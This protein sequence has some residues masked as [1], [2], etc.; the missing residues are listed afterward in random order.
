MPE[1]PDDVHERAVRSADARGEN[2][3]QEV[4]NNY[5]DLAKEDRG[6]T[7]QRTSPQPASKADNADFI[8]NRKPITYRVL[9]ALEGI[10]GVRVYYPRTARQYSE[11]VSRL[12]GQGLTSQSSWGVFSPAN[13]VIVINPNGPDLKQTL[14]H[15]AAHPIV[16]ALMHSRPDLFTKFYEQVLKEEGGKYA[17][18]AEKYKD[19]SPEQQAQEAI[20]EFLADVAAGKVPVRTTKDSLWQRFKAWVQE[21]LAAMGWDMRRVDLGNPKDV[22]DLAAR[23]SKAFNEGIR[24]SGLDG[25]NVDTVLKDGASLSEQRSGIPAVA[26]ALVDRGITDL[27]AIEKE[28][29]RRGRPDLVREVQEEVA[30][31][32]RGQGSAEGDGGKKKRKLTKR[33]VAGQEVDDE[34]KGAITDDAIYYDQLPHRVSKDQAQQVLAHMTDREAEEA[35]LDMKNGMHMATRFIM[36][37]E[38]LRNLNKEKKYDQASAFYD[39]FVPMTTEVGQGISALREL[40]GALGKAG[41][42]E[43]AKRDMKKTLGRDLTEAE[44]KEIDRLAERVDKAPEG[45]PKFDAME[46][47]LKYQAKIAGARW[48]EVH[49][50]IWYANILSG[51][52]THIKNFVANSANFLSLMTSAMARNPRSVPFLVR[53]LVHGLKVGVLEAGATW[54]TGYSPIRGKVEVPAV[55]EWYTFKGG[56]VNPANYLKYVRRAMV[57]ADVFSFEGLKTMRAYQL[58][59]KE[60]A[61]ASTTKVPGESN[62][63]RALNIL[64][65]TDDAFAKAKKQA[66]NEYDE[67]VKEDGSKAGRRKAKRDRA[68]RIYELMEAERPEQLMDDA[69]SYAARGTYNYKPEGLLG[70][71]AQAVNT[72][73]Q[74]MPGIRLIVPFTNIIANIT[75]DALNYTPA[76]LLRA[77]LNRQTFGKYGTEPLSE[78]ER[79]DLLGKAVMGTGLMVAAYMLSAPPDDDKDGEPIIQITAN[80]TGDYRKNYELRETGWQPYSIRVGGKWY[81]YQYTPFMLGLAYIGNLRDF[82]KYRN[83]K[84]TDTNLSKFTVSGTWA[85]RTIL[86]QT[87]IAGLSTFLSL[88]TDPRKDDKSEDF[89]KAVGNMMRGFV[90]PNLYTQGMQELQEMRQEPM[91]E[92]AS[93]W[94]G[95]FIRDIPVLK[96]KYEDKVNA[97]GDP[98]IRNNTVFVNKVKDDEIWELIVD[99][100]AFIGVPGRKTLTIHDPNNDMKERL[101]TDKEYHDFIVMRGKLLKAAIRKNM[102]VMRL[103][104]PESVQKQMKTWKATASKDAK[105]ILFNQLLDAKYPDKRP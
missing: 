81:S 79:A 64:N 65:R 77:G 63:N 71:A 2:V 3:P 67:Q 93:D 92:T 26:K 24:V 46:D 82:E 4:I 37:I 97:L 7:E 16:A 40:G 27:A 41:L 88:L 105:Q 30:A 98:V 52:T 58:A 39:R 14:F 76:G 85:M 78:Q 12:K 101:L 95:R 62:I 100:R 28:L 31:Q 22:R 6:I 59:L 15:E 33:L 34:L 10:G 48:W 43:K 103:S 1:H 69:H 68:R 55:L 23:L 102:D 90:V 99:K 32:M 53:G 91:K 11:M 57:A 21:V 74:E 54:N 61:S 60:A 104:T 47:L 50:A 18:F 72:M 17:K 80:G 9:K 94:Y 13:R 45:R 5:D 38:L 20:V 56:K 87:F 42:V 36:G 70:F 89:A 44:L 84:L 66:D 29:T 83:G 19:R 49:M 25:S 35:V 8:R 86:D 96:D 75:N 73:A 51:P